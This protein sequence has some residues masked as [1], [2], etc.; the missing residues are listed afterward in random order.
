MLSMEGLLGARALEKESLQMWDL[1]KRLEAY[2][3]RVKFLEEENEVLRAE[4][5]RAKS[6]PA[7]RSWRSR[8]EEELRA[9]R[10]TLDDAFKEK[11]RA[12]LARDSLYEEVEQVRSRCERERA[13]R[14]EAKRQLGLS[15]KE[16]EEERRAQIWLKERAAQ[17]EKEV[18]AL[19]EIHEEDRAQLDQ[20][21]AR[22]SCSLES[23]RAPSAAFQPL[24]VEDYSK[25]LAEIWKGAVETYKSEVAQ[26]ESTLG[27]AKENLWQAVEGNRQNQLQLQ[28]LEKD[29]AGLKARKEM[30]EENLSQQWQEQRGEAEKFQLAIEALEQEKQALR[31]QIAQVLEDRQQL[32]HLKMSLSLEVATYRTLLEAESTRLQLPAGEFKLANSLREAKLEM[33]SS[34]LQAMTP[35]PRKLLPWD[36][37]LSPMVF[38]KTESKMHLLRT[39]TESPRLQTAAL[40]QSRRPITREL[41]K[42]IT[43]FQFS[44]RQSIDTAGPSNAASGPVGASQGLAATEIKTVARSFSRE[45]PELLN[46]PRSAMPEP[47]GQPPS[48]LE[49]DR[50]AEL[51]AQKEAGEM[52]KEDEDA[53]REEGRDASEEPPGKPVPRELLYPDLLVTEALEDALREVKQDANTAEGSSPLCTDWAPL[54]EVHGLAVPPAAEELD[55]EIMCELEGL[56]DPGQSLEAVSGTSRE[57]DSDL[58]PQPEDSTGQPGMQKESGQLWSPSRETK[59]YSSHAEVQDSEAEICMA[60]AFSMQSLPAAPQEPPLRG[61]EEEDWEQGVQSPIQQDKEVP[62]EMRDPSPR[63]DEEQPS[64]ETREDASSWEQDE[65]KEEET[66]PLQS[67]EEREEAEAICRSAEPLGNDVVVLTEP[68]RE[69]WEVGAHGRSTQAGSSEE[70]DRGEEDLE[71]MSTEALHLSED[72]ERREHWSPSRE[73]EEYSF[74]AGAQESDFF[75]AEIQAT[76]AFSMQNCPALPVENLAEQLQTTEVEAKRLQKTEMVLE[77]EGKVEVATEAQDFGISGDEVSFGAEEA[78]TLDAAREGGDEHK[79]KLEGEV[80]GSEILCMGHEGLRQ[81]EGSLEETGDLQEGTSGQDTGPGEEVLEM[82]QRQESWGREGD[83]EEDYRRSPSL[84]RGEE[85]AEGYS[86]DGEGAEVLAQ[87]GHT[88]TSMGAADS[89]EEQ[90]Q[91]SLDSEV[92]ER[93]EE[94]DADVGHGAGQE[95][96]TQDSRAEQAGPSTELMGETQHTPERP[97]E[98]IQS[99]PTLPPVDSPHQEILEGPEKAWEGLQPSPETQ[100]KATT[101][102]EHNEY[103]EPD[104]LD[105][106]SKMHPLGQGDFSES[107]DSLASQ[108][109]LDLK[110][111]GAD[112]ELDR[113]TRIRLEETLPDSTPL[114]VYEGEML[115]QNVSSQEPPAAEGMADPAPSSSVSLE[116]AGQVQTGAEPTGSRDSGSSEE[117]TAGT[118]PLESTEEEGYFMVSAAP[119]ET[120]SWEEVEGSEDFEEI[121]AEAAGTLGVDLSLGT[122]QPGMQEN[123]GHCGESTDEPTEG[124]G[125]DI[126]QAE[127]SKDEGDWGV[128][129]EE[130]ST[131]TV[132]EDQAPLEE[133]TVGSEGLAAELDAGQD[134]EAG[135]LPQED[136]KPCPSDMAPEPEESGVSPENVVQDGAQTPKAI[137]P[138]TGDA[139][140][141]SPLT[142]VADL[143]EIVLEGQALAGQTAVDGS[144]P[145]KDVQELDITLAPPDGPKASSQGDNSGQRKEDAEKSQEVL[146]VSPDTAEMLPASVMKDSDILEIV[147]Q[148]LEFN[149]ELML[150]TRLPELPDDA[151]Q[152]ALGTGEASEPA[153]EA[154]SDG[155]DSSSGTDELRTVHEALEDSSPGTKGLVTSGLIWAENH[156]TADLNGVHHEARLAE[157]AE[158]TEEILNGISDLQVPDGHNGCEEIAIPS[159]LHGQ[160]PDTFPVYQSSLPRSDEE[161]HQD[162]DTPVEKAPMPLDPD[163]CK[164]AD[165]LQCGKT[166][167]AQPISVPSAFGDEILHLSPGQPLQ[168]Q[169]KDAQGSW[170][171]EDD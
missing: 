52:G 170:S 35:E 73:I 40:P 27:Q 113:S 5:Q 20:E 137:S 134:G 150:G 45:S 158:F 39:P 38:Q 14:D 109:D 6:S 155:S 75:Q 12:E 99:P 139:A 171:S 31:V 162:G 56:T 3:A 151:G 30:L 119:H 142:T 135:E 19:M 120:P 50:E 129:D 143:G 148:A 117:H 42:A 166:L 44:S 85:V 54:E 111:E 57:V 160:D 83:M 16:L 46:S 163:S 77:D 103:E 71:V 4:I 84:E 1:N 128:H 110:A 97:S 76:Q 2:L 32:M 34:K 98:D 8:Y 146:V 41:P 74:Q 100:G 167:E 89:R 115:A 10:A 93:R 105:V 28:Q 164:L 112:E 125:A 43:G 121:Q 13:A 165:I 90:T 25:R 95:P 156:A 24:E 149:Q 101:R 88:M 114:H 123:M 145:S 102:G 80:S 141:V 86:E 130:L 21:V 58:Q 29:L 87:A 66:P 62:W 68:T 60:Q 9:L 7:E 79:E 81:D 153:P 69:S 108:E 59:D 64:A 169:P 65:S 168:H 18:E 11:C 15:K 92:Q 152:P 133:P 157:L 47:L 17:L 107:E 127:T 122:A 96:P 23:F 131:A 126:A 67:P 61:D 138:G 70:F 26:L 140:K 154:R 53:M 94:E 82:P 72:E 144:L 22:F 78:E 91:G 106:A 136:S 104:N 124:L 37:R 161:G 132:P 63:Q 116:G 159:A 49:G 55:G 118:G 36:H 51:G 48:D 147:E 33:S